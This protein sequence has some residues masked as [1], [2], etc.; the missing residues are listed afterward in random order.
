M[1]NKNISRRTAIKYMGVAGV[2]AAGIL[3]G[4]GCSKTEKEIIYNEEDIIPCNALDCSDSGCESNNSNSE[5]ACCPNNSA[6]CSDNK[7]G[8]CACKAE[9]FCPANVYI[10]EVFILY[11]ECVREG[12]L[13]DI[14]SQDLTERDKQKLK[15]QSRAFLSKMDKIPQNRRAERCTKCG[16]CIPYCEHIENVQ[17]EIIRIADL[18]KSI[19]N[20]R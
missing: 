5:G 15:K 14:S 20:M 10:S 17:D 13:P 2:G 1:E 7:T 12:N 4:I 19:K 16:E 6:S 11:N 18:T 9:P 3:L 8:R